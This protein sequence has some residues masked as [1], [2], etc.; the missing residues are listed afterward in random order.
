LS[1]CRDALAG[2]L[3]PLKIGAFIDAHDFAAI[4]AR[5][6]LWIC[7]ESTSLTTS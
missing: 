3:L 7:I 5:F 1:R 2:V 4:R 6:R